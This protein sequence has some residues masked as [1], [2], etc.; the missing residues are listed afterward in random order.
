MRPELRNDLILAAIF[1]AVIYMVTG[2]WI[3]TLVFMASLAWHE[4]GHV[5]AFRQAG[6]QRVRWRF[7]PFLGAVAWSSAPTRT[8]LERLYI[9]LMGP[10]FSLILLVLCVLAFQAVDPRSAAAP[11]LAYAILS[12]G[13][14]NALNLLPLAPLDGSHVLKAM[15]AGWA[16]PG[17][18]RQILIVSGALLVILAFLKGLFFIAVF[19]MLN[20]VNLLRDEET[21]DPAAMA[22]LTPRERLLGAVAYVTTLLAHGLAG[23]PWISDFMG[24]AA[25]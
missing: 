7:I 15:L 24:W 13:F 25:P 16:P 18:A 14:L 21:A 22:L 2:N 4:Y 8:Q 20:V 1:F 3:L 6:H 9:A 5:L 10:G 23:W 19:A 12:I 11:V 17:L